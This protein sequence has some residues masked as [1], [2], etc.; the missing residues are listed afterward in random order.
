[1]NFFANNKGVTLMELLLSIALLGIVISAGYGL[2]YQGI[3][4]FHISDNQIDV[5]REVWLVSDFITN[6][7]R[8][9]VDIQLF[10]SIT[11]AN[12]PEPIPTNNDNNYIVLDNLMIKRLNKD[13]TA[14][15]TSEMFT[16]L[17]FK[18]IKHTGGQNLVELTVGANKRNQDYELTTEIYLN[19]LSEIDTTSA[20]RHVIRY[21][22]P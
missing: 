16:R 9:A 20:V 17:D 1:M 2:F 22:K 5:Q 14:D 12:I 7:L 6:E 4:F 13:G 21:K 8:N 15:K 18:L 11:E 3:R 10:S 19:N